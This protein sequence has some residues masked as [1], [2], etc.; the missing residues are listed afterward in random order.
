MD[1]GHQITDLGGRD[2]KSTWWLQACL[3]QLISMLIEESLD[4]E[5][6]NN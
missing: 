3:G 2:T 5:L 6:V 1:F 4:G